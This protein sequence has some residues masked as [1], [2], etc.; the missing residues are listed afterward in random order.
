MKLTGGAGRLA[1]G[2]GLRGQLALASRLS[3]Q[4]ALALLLSTACSRAAEK[5]VPPP[6]LLDSEGKPLAPAPSAPVAPAQGPAQ[7]TVYDFERPAPSPAANTAQNLG[8]SPPA[9]RA[10]AGAGGNRDLAAELSS[11]LNQVTDCVA[12]AEAAKQPSGR[13]VVNVS[14]YVLGTGS[15]SR[16]TVDAP[17][18]PADAL[19]CLQRRVMAIKLAEP[20]PDAPTNVRGSTTVEIKA[21]G[22][23]PTAATPPPT[24]PPANPNVARGE[25]GAELARPDQA[26]LAGPP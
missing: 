17:G 4:L 18:Q 6:G 20:V 26:D 24:K 21:V 2:A 19:A 16:A 10:P 13:L 15:I 25:P 5:P 9:G 11:A 22:P 7:P 8:M 14:A 1:L 3:G 12:P 23:K